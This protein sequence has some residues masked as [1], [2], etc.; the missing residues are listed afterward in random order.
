[1][2]LEVQVQED[3]TLLYFSDGPVVVTGPIRGW[4]MLPNGK[5]VNV[6]SNV[7]EA[8]DEDEAAAIAD[9]VSKRY[10]DEGHPRMKGVPF[11]YIP[12]TIVSEE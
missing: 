11:E 2:A 7:V 8:E 10:R 3:G 1:M 5:T 12:S 4:V 9:E 6:D